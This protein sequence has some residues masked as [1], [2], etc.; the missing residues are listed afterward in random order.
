MIPQIGTDR[1]RPG[2]WAT[3]LVLAWL[4]CLGPAQAAPDSRD[5]QDPK[6]TAEQLQALQA[7]IKR[8]QKSLESDHDRKDRLQRDLRQAE[9][10]IGEVSRELQR[11]QEQLATQDAQ[12][13]RLQREQA[14]AHEHF[15]T[16]KTQLARD[17]RAAYHMGQQE[18]L[19]LILNQEDPARM[20]RALVYYRYFAEA[21]GARMQE[22]NAQLEGMA[23]RERQIVQQQETL[24]R[25]QQQQRNKADSLKTHQTSRSAL[26][27]RIKQG[28][29]DKDAE[30]VQLT[31][32][33]KR[34]QELVRSLRDLLADIPQDAGNQEPFGKRK[35]RLAW[36][37]SGKLLAR[38]G[39]KRARSD[40]T[41]RGVLIN[42]PP[43]SE[44]RA[45]SHGRVAFADWL[46]G[47]GLLIIVDHGEGY[48][49]LY[50]HNQSLFKETGEWVQG[51][52]AIASVGKSGGQESTGLYFEVRKDGRPLNPSQWCRNS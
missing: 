14:A 15:T 17:A 39:T 23:Q 48:M 40:Q 37:S 12:L 1:S 44:V 13:A 26:L 5:A 49:T 47:F 43:G 50:G 16:L 2:V 32:D 9:K 6:A 38:F 41:W 10:S 51:G 4:L 3:V 19:K 33:E 42:A 36:P 28:I 25:L 31:R 45:V 35:G 34:L 11:L 8:L 20:G 29:Q 18:P 22:V 30:L 52:E 46:R 7:K 24:A 27:A 21:R